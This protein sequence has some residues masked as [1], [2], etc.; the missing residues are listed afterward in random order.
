M[1]YGFVHQTFR[2]LCGS[3]HTLSV[4]PVIVW[5][6]KEPCRSPFQLYRSLAGVRNL[7]SKTATLCKPEIADE[8]GQNCPRLGKIGQ[9]NDFTD[10]AGF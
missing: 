1:N 8:S 5:N 3:E 2:R 10:L 4:I 7:F 9:H 6:T